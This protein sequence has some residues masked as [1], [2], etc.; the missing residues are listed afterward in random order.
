MG[1]L[2]FGFT[3]WIRTTQMVEF[4][5]WISDTS[6]SGWIVTHFWAIPIFQC[7]HIV[8]IAASFSSLLMMNARIFGIAGSSGV[9]ETSQRYIKVLWWAILVLVLSGILMIVGE[10]VRELIN[11]IFWIKMLLVT[12]GILVT[13]WFHKGIIRGLV[14]GRDISAGAK[15][16]AVFL[17]ILWCLIILCGRWIA[18]APV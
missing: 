9:V 18:Y 13:I 14:K 11:P 15:L 8:A 1:D 17:I 6:L 2:L 4:A 7:I 16:T 10:P 12:F 5:L 3:E